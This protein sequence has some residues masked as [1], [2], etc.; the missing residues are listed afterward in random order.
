MAMN[1]LLPEK[2]GIR[3]DLIRKKLDNSIFG[4]NIIFYETL[5]STNSLAK[6]L[7]GSGSPEGTI[8]LA[9]KQTAGR[10]RLG[11]QWLSPRHANLLFSL[12]LRPSIEGNEVF[13]LTMIFALAIIEG[14]EESC[15][16]K[17][18]IKW[19]NDIY[20]DRKKLGGILTEFK[21]RR[22]K[23][24]YVILGL[25]LNVN[26]KP[27]DDD[28]F[29]YPATSLLAETGDKISREEL[30]AL[31]IKR[32]EFFFRELLLGKVNELN[33]KWNER[34]MLLGKRV[35]M[36]TSDGIIRG[37]ASRVDK[38]GALIILDDHGREQKIICGDVLLAKTKILRGKEG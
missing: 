36:G 7:A 8:V 18:M 22:K 38:N 16:L 5:P 12:L 29:L 30:L 28:S 17:P 4:G 19:P 11:R 26:W 21:I 25:G 24:E 32:F 34:S 2:D 37:K 1:S 27:E 33:K 10:G 3:P 6:N 13:R 23:V 31:I 35:E 9:E 20:V 14:V 15:G